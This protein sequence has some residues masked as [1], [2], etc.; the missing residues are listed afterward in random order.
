MYLQKLKAWLI[1]DTK[2]KMRK[3]HPRQMKRIHMLCK[4]IR[5]IGLQIK[6]QNPRHVSGQFSGL[7]YKETSSWKGIS[8]FVNN[9]TKV[10]KGCN[11][12]ICKLQVRVD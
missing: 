9:E 10:G 8:E 4:E 7:L 2:K 6:Y 1:P 12:M 11:C 5:Q 3:H